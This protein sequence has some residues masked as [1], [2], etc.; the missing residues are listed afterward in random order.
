MAVS[1]ARGALG[2][3]Q[4]R[5]PW[6]V[7]CAPEVSSGPHPPVIASLRPSL[8]SGRRYL[9]DRGRPHRARQAPPPGKA[10]G[11][12]SQAP[13]GRRACRRGSSPSGRPARALASVARPLSLPAGPQVQDAAKNIPKEKRY[14]GETASRGS[15]PRTRA[16]KGA[17][18]RRRQ[19]F[20][21]WHETSRFRVASRIRPA[22]TPARRPWFRALSALLRL[23]ASPP[24]LPRHGEA[25][26]DGGRQGPHKRVAPRKTCPC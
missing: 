18:A 19:T 8:R 5:G 14:K 6:F 4:G 25:D 23:V 26:L 7:C 10:A 1:P 13:R 16:A 24:C 22:P 11:S 17:S 15:P 20:A 2:E 12:G 3:G 21:A 9:Q